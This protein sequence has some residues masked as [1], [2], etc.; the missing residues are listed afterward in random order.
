MTTI[1][2]IAAMTVTLGWWI[3]P[4]VL[5]IA[6]LAWAAHEEAGNH[7]IGAGLCFI[8]TLVPV[9]FIWVVYLGLCLLLK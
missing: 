5:T 1:P 9:L 3:L 7:G 6:L 4:A 8:M 2:I